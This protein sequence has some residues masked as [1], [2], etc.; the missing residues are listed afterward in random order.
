[1]SASCVPFSAPVADVWDE[2]QAALSGSA[3]YRQ[4]AVRTVNQAVGRVIR[5]R[6]DYGAVL[7][8]DE[9]FGHSTLLGTL[10]T[11]L[12]PFVSVF[13]QFGE[14]QGSLVRFFKRAA[15]L[16]Q[17]KVRLAFVHPAQV[18]LL[19]RWVAHVYVCAA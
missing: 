10:P 17:L 12:R 1:M 4:Q 7:L 3:W 14:A 16:P 11:W 8:C 13:R 19:T 5:H 15:T 18:P 6:Y 9:R 2:G